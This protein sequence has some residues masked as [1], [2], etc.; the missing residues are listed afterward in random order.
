[1]AERCPS[2]GHENIAGALICEKCYSLLIKVDPNAQSTTR[3]SGGERW[4]TT[5]QLP[6]LPDQ[7]AIQI[8]RKGPARPDAVAL[9]VGDHD[10]P[11]ILQIT[12]Q[13]ILGRYTPHSVSQPRVD[14]TPYGA[15]DKGVSRMH[16]IL[17]R[18]DAGLV[19]EDMASSNGTWL[20]GKR[21]QPYTPAVIRSGD[22][23]RLG[24]L[25]IEI[26]L[27]GEGQAPDESRE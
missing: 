6:E 18:S 16:I 27:G 2:C 25:E 22:R 1:M 12:S 9:Y 10:A 23:L 17:R 20:N 15:F 26:H 8:G 24:Q 13:A 3:L 7:P 14:L 19:I 21:L 11:L 4:G 5:P